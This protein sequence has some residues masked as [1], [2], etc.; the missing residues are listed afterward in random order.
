MPKTNWG[1]AAGGA[2]SGASTGFSLGGPVGGVIGG[3]AG[4][5]LGLFG[6]KK[7]KKKKKLSTFDKN[8]QKLHDE[9]FDAFHGQGPLADIY[10]YDPEKANDVFD[11]MIGSKAYRNF[12][13]NIVPK[14]TGQF[15]NSGLMNSSYAGDA[16]S[17]AGRDVQESLDAQ[18]A[19]YLYNTEQSSKQAK[20]N[21]LNSYQDRQTFAYDMADS[22]DG[23]GGGG[24]FDNIL[25]SITPKTTDWM[26]DL[27]FKYLP[28]G[29]H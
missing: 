23:G 18:R 6:G 1:G 12:N 3:V 28:G 19:N 9:Q 17:K 27:A 13:E 11:K 15:R 29:F 10:G 7:K 5:L 24:W 21:A 4:G 16:L 26:E 20:Q 22:G 14:I 8:Q 2:A 25:N